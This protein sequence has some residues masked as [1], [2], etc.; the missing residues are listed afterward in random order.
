MWVSFLFWMF[1][2][3]SIMEPFRLWLPVFRIEFRASLAFEVALAFF[4]FAVRISCIVREN[5]LVQV[6]FLFCIV[7]IARTLLPHIVMF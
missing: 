5:Y 1:Y 2:E 6:E 4:C 7:A 3:V